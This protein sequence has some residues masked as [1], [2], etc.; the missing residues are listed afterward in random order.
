MNREM[1]WDEYFGIG[2][3]FPCSISDTRMYFLYDSSIMCDM[4]RAGVET[5]TSKKYS[6]RS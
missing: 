3:T 1:T 5:A 2:T 4:A 6:A